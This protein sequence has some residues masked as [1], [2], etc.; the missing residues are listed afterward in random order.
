MTIPF[1]ILRGL[2]AIDFRVGRLAKPW[3]DGSGDF[4]RRA[5]FIDDSLCLRRSEPEKWG[6]YQL[7]AH[8][9]LLLFS[10]SGIKQRS[11]LG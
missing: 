7:N 2:C 3:I 10:L 11:F 5:V 4:L 6:F 9:M 8:G 1:F